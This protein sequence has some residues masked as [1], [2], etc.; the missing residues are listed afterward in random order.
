MSASTIP[1]PVRSPQPSLKLALCNSATP[2]VAS[3]GYYDWVLFL[4]AFDAQ[5]NRLVTHNPSSVRRVHYK[6]HPT[7][8]RPEVTL[9]R[10]STGD[11]AAPP[12]VLVQR[13]WGT[14]TVGAVVELEDSREVRLRHELSFEPGMHIGP[15][16]TVPEA[17]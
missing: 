9:E 7:F 14:F 2:S 6:L 15:A 1:H 13:G 3:E 10:S 17:H 12:F 4:A 8:P 16:A 5:S 11:D